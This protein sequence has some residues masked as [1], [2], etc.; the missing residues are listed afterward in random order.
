MAAKICDDADKSTHPADIADAIRALIDQP[1][2][3]A[4]QE[5]IDGWVSVP[6]E[7]TPAMLDALENALTNWKNNED[8]YKAI[9][10]VILQSK[11]AKG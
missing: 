5:L 7:P 11:P 1:E 4:S 10:D 6:I 9:I 8:C 3:P 2:P